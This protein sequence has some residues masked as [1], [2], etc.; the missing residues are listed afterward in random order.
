MIKRGF[1]Q[2]YLFC[3]FLKSGGKTK[4]LM[5][6]KKKIVRKLSWKHST[7]RGGKYE[8]TKPESARINTRSRAGLL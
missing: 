1:C 5:K 4:L 2:M 3:D 7:K 8:S 6:K